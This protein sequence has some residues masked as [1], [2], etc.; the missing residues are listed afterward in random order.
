M[1][2]FVNLITD[3]VRLCTHGCCMRGRSNTGGIHA[4][5]IYWMPGK[6]A[7]K[8]LGLIRY[9]WAS[10][11]RER[12]PQLGYPISEELIPDPWIGNRRPDVIK[13]LSINL[14]LDVI[15]LPAEAVDAG[16]PSTVVN[17]AKTAPTTAASRATAS[18]MPPSRPSSRYSRPNWSGGMH[19]KRATTSAMPLSNTSTVA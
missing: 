9:F 8:V 2:T 18:T 1:Q 6:G 19:G 16:F 3:H 7:H 12:H 15:K 5:S 11:G 17:M 14:P 10:K 13:K 4:G